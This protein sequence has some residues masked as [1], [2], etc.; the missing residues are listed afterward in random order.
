MG[1]SPSGAP[2]AQ[3]TTSADAQLAESGASAPQN[4]FVR[5]LRDS[6]VA[7]L[8]GTGGLRMAGDRLTP[9]QPVTSMA[10]ESATMKYS[11]EKTS[12]APGSQYLAYSA[13]PTRVTG[14]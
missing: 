5:Q 1:A 13:S 12:K 6:A 4:D 14:A 10:E 2:G 3:R 9:L 8:T 11:P 7:K